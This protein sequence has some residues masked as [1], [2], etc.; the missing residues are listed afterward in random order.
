MGRS[1]TI[2]PFF[3]DLNL[4]R[5]ILTPSMPLASGLSQLVSGNGVAFEAALRKC[6]CGQPQNVCADCPEQISCA[7]ALLTA[8]KLSHD[9]ELVRR[10]QR[11]SLP[12]V[13]DTSLTAVSELG[14]TLL[15]PACQEVTLFLRAV[16]LVLGQQAGWRIKTLDY[17][18]TSF[19][20]DPA[21]KQ[22]LDSV[23]VLSV[24]ELLHQYQQQ[25]TDCN[26]VTLNLHSPLRL[27]QQGRE[28][29][30]FLPDQFIRMLLRRLSSLAA[31]YGVAADAQLF[32]TL[33]ELAAEVKLVSAGQ[34]KQT[35]S[36]SAPRGIR[37]S[38]ILTGPFT[39]LGPYLALG[40]LLHVGKGASYGLG[41]YAV[42]VN[43]LDIMNRG[44]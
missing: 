42:S 23:A 11:P 8:R 33:V 30:K 4:V 32:R 31:Y 3:M 1:V 16:A 20:L 9:T 41:Q 34:V 26:S 12:F 19:C 37:G 7:F 39:D 28:L 22:G 43:N 2:A 15:G 35:E 5:L 17:Q 18:G 6:C 13:F 29:N 44:T 14:L 10:H 21:S 27:M 25:F 36:R 40:C 24:Q 38:F